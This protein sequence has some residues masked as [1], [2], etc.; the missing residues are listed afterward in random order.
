MSKDSLVQ[1]GIGIVTETKPHGERYASVFLLEKAQLADEEVNSDE[2][3]SVNIELSD[4]TV[5]QLNVKEKFSVQAKWLRIGDSQRITPPDLVV[6]HHV[7]IYQKPGY[8]E[9]YW[10]KLFEENDIGLQEVVTYGWIAK[11][12]DDTAE[13]D[14]S[15]LEKMY[16]LTVSTKDGE[17]RF[18][19]T[20]A[21]EEQTTYNFFLDTM[22]G[23][24]GFED[25][26]G[27]FFT[28]D[29]VNSIRKINILKDYN[30]KIG[31]TRNSYIVKN[32]NIKTDAEY[33]L[34]V[35]SI[36][37]ME[38]KADYNYRGKGTYNFDNNGDYNIKNV[39]NIQFKTM[40]EMIFQSN[41]D[42][43]ILS[44]GGK[45]SIIS[46]SGISVS[47]PTIDLVGVISCGALTCGALSVGG[48]APQ[49]PALKQ[50][51]IPGADMSKLED[52]MKVLEEATKVDDEEGEDSGGS[53][54]SSGTKSRSTRNGN[55]SKDSEEEE[56]P[57]K[58]ETK[59]SEPEK[60]KEP[61]KSVSTYE[62]PS[63]INAKA[64]MN[65]NVE[66]TYEVAS[67]GSM[68][69]STEAELKVE[70]QIAKLQAQ[71]ATIKADGGLSLQ[72]SGGDLM[73]L[74]ISIVD[75]LTTAI[76]SPHGSAN[77]PTV[78]TGAGAIAGA[79]I[80]PMLTA[81]KGGATRSI[82]SSDFRLASLGIA[83]E[84]EKNP[85]DVSEIIEKIK[86]L[87]I[88][89]PPKEENDEKDES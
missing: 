37:S 41:Q 32:E 66:G 34:Y 81:F 42:V 23:I 68:G 80:K 62:K 89:V 73:D 54:G 40:K 8:D 86:S 76:D 85:F 3:T 5:K 57:W 58:D 56:D 75:T 30:T 6:G 63:E 55:S 19:T 72:G 29:S 38:V 18:K 70:S 78:P 45:I 43:T 65:V 79:T 25:K 1:V 50:A 71:M 88:P 74:L 33:N 15:Y 49:P 48:A 2:E 14:P 11:H 28:F 69:I 16:R 35:G 31:E 12:K 24:M 17:I 27:N 26:Q 10:V 7:M 52:A 87:P 51:D 9:F 21:N 59:P 64:N 60:L 44:N 39:G 77:G 67:K 36:H 22:N 46:G 13:V 83:P 82:R 84:E 47:A 20:D 53:S 4:G 61:D